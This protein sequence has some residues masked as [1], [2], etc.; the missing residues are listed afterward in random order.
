EEKG[1]VVHRSKRGLLG[2]LARQSPM[3]YILP[4]LILYGLFYFYPLIWTPYLSL[5]TWDGV[6]A[7]AFVGLKNYIELFTSDRYFFVT[8]LHN[9]VWLILGMT[10]P[11]TIGMCLALL[12]VR[13]RLHARVVFRTIYF[14][15][16]VPSAVIVALIWKWIY[17]PGYGALINI[18]PGIGL[19]GLAFG[20]LGNSNSALLAIFITWT[21]V[22]YGFCMIIFIAA[23]Q[24]LD[25]TYI[26]AAKVD[27]ANG[28]QR[29]WFILIPFMSRSITTVM[30]L[31]ALAS[32][33][34]FDLVYV[35]T[36]GGP[37]VSTLVMGVYMYNRAFSYSKVG[38]GC[39]I[40]TML[41]LLILVFS[42]FFLRTR[43][44]AEVEL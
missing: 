21:W 6:R 33:Q 5:F 13:T 39:A 41:G 37:G 8:L 25:E 17:A 19:N 14:L 43:K 22:I 23:L 16:M 31:L 42:L 40:A 3:V 24:G 20:W 7:K 29:L 18:L 28:F 15:P 27:G 30:L 44:A 4:G 10:V 12:L 38:Y 11:V 26:D 2:F 1:L 36:R 34:V 35:M 9:F 32:L